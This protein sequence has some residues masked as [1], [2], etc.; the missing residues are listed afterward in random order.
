M[1][2][3]F[4]SLMNGSHWGGSEEMWYRTALWMSENG[5]SIGVCCYDWAGKQEKLAQLKD[6]GAAIFLLPQKKGLFYSKKLRSV[7]NKVPFENY[8]LVFV[9]QGGYKEVVYPPFNELYKRFNKYSLS[10]H[11]YDETE[12]LSSSRRASLKAWMENA[13]IN[14]AAARK[15]FQFIENKFR[16]TLSRKEVWVNPI[17]IIYPGNPATYPPL[18]NGNYTWTMLAELDVLRK[19]QDMLIQVLSSA[20]WK[21]RNWQFHLYGKGKDE[22]LLKQ[23]IREKGLSEKVI[24][25]GYTNDVRS[26]LENTHLLF[27]CT[28]IDA[29]PISVVEAMSMARPCVVSKVGDMPYWIEDGKNGFVIDPLTLSAIDNKLEDCWQQKDNWEKL[30][31]NAFEVFQQKYPHHYGKEVA[32]RI[33]SL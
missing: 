13:A 19:S 31:R 26:V 1:K 23:L 6:N 29:M 8:D 9:N 10:F 27:Q 25:Q 16:F 24:L 2:I 30:G 20:K 21:E 32:S 7:L 3:L 5:H 33:L 22:G 11:N 18:A 28:R 12:T 14:I 17:T 15:V 4:L